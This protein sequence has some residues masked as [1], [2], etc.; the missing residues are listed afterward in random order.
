MTPAE[1]DAVRY[2]AR[3]IVDCE[4]P[5]R[6]RRELARAVL[7][8]V[9]PD[10]AGPPPGMRVFY[11][12]QIK[13]YDHRER[14]GPT[15]I[16]DDTDSERLAWALL[17]A[18]AKARDACTRGDRGPYRCRAVPDRIDVIARLRTIRAGGG[19]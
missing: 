9:P 6:G 3:C 8:F 19:A 14:K 10:G 12:G 2:L 11:D 13:I 18:V 5:I 4:T 15:L 16:L 17:A 1:R 7:A